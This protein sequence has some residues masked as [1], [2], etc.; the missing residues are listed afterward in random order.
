MNLKKFSRK[1]GA[2]FLVLSLTLS[3]TAC[4]TILYPERR[5][6]TSG[7]IDPGVAILDG[8]GLVVFI[9]PGLIAFGID[10]TT[11]TIYLPH[12]KKT[13]EA[14]GNLKTVHLKPG[15]RT[16]EK[17]GKIISKETGKT[18]N[19]ARKDLKAYVVEPG[20][21]AAESLRTLATEKTAEN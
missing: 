15:Q 19:L 10:F 5:G 9:V 4:G 18:V 13:A 6:Q 17:L 14:N 2:A 12:G 20:R 11:G 21:S 16:P 1:L 7:K 3:L 8:V